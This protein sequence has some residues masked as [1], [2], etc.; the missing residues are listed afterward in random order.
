MST[1]P[2]SLNTPQLTELIHRLDKE[3]PKP[4]PPLQHRSVFELLIAVILS[5]QCTDARVN[6]ITPLLFPKNRP[7]TPEDLLTLGEAKVKHIIHPCGFFNTKSKAILA[8]AAQIQKLGGVPNRFEELI[9][10][11]GVGGKTAQVILA[12]WFKQDAFPVDTHVHRVC[13]RLGLAHSKKNV[14][15]TER[16]VKARVP[17]EHWS[18]LHLQLVFHGR[19]TCTAYK[20]K[21]G[22]CPLFDLCQWSQKDKNASRDS[23]ISTS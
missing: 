9:K 21:C 16:E 4:E 12:Q 5:A 20:P 11:P 18:K 8:T 19:K 23:L 13:N 7:C 10:L 2:T 22:T 14:A 1:T 6:T 17:K 3:F 15:K